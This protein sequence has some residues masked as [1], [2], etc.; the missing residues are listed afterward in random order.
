MDTNCDVCGKPFSQK[1]H[2]DRHRATL[3]PHAP[4]LYTCTE[5]GCNVGFAFPSDLTA[6]VKSVHYNDCKCCDYNFKNISNWNRHR[7]AC[8]DSFD[9]KLTHSK[10]QTEEGENYL[11]KIYLVIHVSG[12][13]FKIGN[14]KQ[15]MS[16]RLAYLKSQNGEEMFVS[17]SWNVSEKFMQQ[18]VIERLE[19]ELHV[20][21]LELGFLQKKNR[22]EYFYFRNKELEEKLIQ[23]FIQSIVEK[24]EEKEALFLDTVVVEHVQRKTEKRKYE[25]AT[26]PTEAQLKKRKYNKEYHQN[27]KGKW[28]YCATNGTGIVKV[29]HTSMAPVQRLQIFNSKKS[30][31]G[32]FTLMQ[33]FPLGDGY[34]VENM[35]LHLEG[36]VIEKMGINFRRIAGTREHFACSNEDHEK[37]I[38]IIENVIIKNT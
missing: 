34:E 35:R 32:I 10:V 22:L 13:Y 14:T 31:H 18:I 8:H 6:H 11:P 20:H 7:L 38:K 19:K 9:D 3:H 25:K 4:P 2:Y 30:N 16:Q 36:L 29:G 17:K 27:N 5:N 1:C 28:L 15:P 37:V 23:D 33:A 24:H 26:S 12:A 21:M